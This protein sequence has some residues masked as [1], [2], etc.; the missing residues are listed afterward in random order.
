MQVKTHTSISRLRLAS[1]SKQVTFFRVW[2]GLR[3]SNNRLSVETVDR[4]LLID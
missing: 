3:E 2:L 1:N 4:Y